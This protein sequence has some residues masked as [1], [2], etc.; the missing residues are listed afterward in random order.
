[1]RL[2][3]EARGVG[4]VMGRKFIAEVLNHTPLPA[5]TR[6]SV[7]LVWVVPDKRRRDA[8]NPVPTLKALCDG[9]VDA[10]LVPDDTPEFMEKLMPVIVYVKGE[11][12]VELTL[13]VLETIGETN[14]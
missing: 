13:E 2:S 11:L 9:L 14:D 12:R 6:V 4:M 1:M 5:G 8:E 10:G 3:R 7:G